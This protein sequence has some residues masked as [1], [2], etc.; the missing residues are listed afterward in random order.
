MIQIPAALKVASLAA[1]YWKP[2]AAVLLVVCVLLLTYATGRSHA[3]RAWERRY[4]AAV[5]D[6]KAAVARAAEQTRAAE[7]EKLRT[8]TAWRTHVAQR[9]KEYRDEKAATAAALAAE[10]V[11]NVR[12]RDA[13]DHFVK[14]SGSSSDPAAAC[15]DLRSRVTTLGALLQEAD[16]LAGESA[17]AADRT[18]DGLALCRDYAQIIQAR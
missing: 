18:R 7:A 5:A 2:I 12:L 6:W 3:N 4:D 17:T 8:E 16:G 14:A 11:S 9:E 1:N 13:I 15:G 10:R